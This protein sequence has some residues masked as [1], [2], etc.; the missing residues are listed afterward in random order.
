VVRFVTRMA[1][2][3]KLA[4]VRNPLLALVLLGVVTNRTV[5]AWL[6]S[7]L[8]TSLFNFSVT[9]WVYCGLTPRGRRGRCWLL[10]LSLSAVCIALTRPDGLLYW[11]ATLA[12][13]AVECSGRAAPRRFSALASTLA[14]LTVPLHA[15]WRRST[16]GYW[17]PNTYYAKYA[18]PWP[19]SG[20]RYLECFVIEYGIWVWLLLAVAWGAVALRGGVPGRAA[21][22]VT[23]VLG[24][25]AGQ[26]AYYTL[27]IG[28]DHFEYRVYSH[29]IPLLFVSALWLAARLSTRPLVVGALLASF[30]VASWP[31]PWLHYLDTRHL[32]LQGVIHKPTQPVAHHF[33]GW[34]APLVRHWDAQQAWLMAHMVGTR[35][36]VHKTF[37]EFQRALFPD[38]SVGSQIPWAERGVLILGSVGVPGWVLPEVA[39]IDRLG[40]TDRVIGHSP[41]SRPMRRMAHDRTPPPGYL[42]CF[43]PNVELSRGAAIVKRRTVPLT[44]DD[45]RRCQ[46]REWY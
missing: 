35:H 29:L 1:L 4:R 45:I 20:L 21:L 19:E 5:L 11:A 7:G 12:M 30:I 39:I 38:R 36:Q 2:P 6:S 34:L 24:A 26:A 16:Y 44:D 42:A 10:S 32:T 22:R 41:L 23:L 13:I 40:L 18:A 15:I 43:R 9:W 14:L 31:I 33:P 25:L 27:I 3:E 17:L 8:E 37:Y 28:G 46:E